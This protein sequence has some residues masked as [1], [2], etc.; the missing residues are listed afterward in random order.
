MSLSVF[1]KCT[2]LTGGS[3][4]RNQNLKNDK[5]REIYLFF[6]PPSRL[7]QLQLINDINCKSAYV[8]ALPACMLVCADESSPRRYSGTFAAHHHCA[9]RAGEL[10]LLSDKRILYVCA[11]WHWFA[12]SQSSDSGQNF[13]IRA[14]RFVANVGQPWC[15]YILASGICTWP[16]VQRQNWKMVEGTLFDISINNKKFYVAFRTTV[17]A[18][19]AARTRRTLARF[20]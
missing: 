13:G 7:I 10:S 4:I 15:A 17:K 14:W 6:L 12:V 11:H 8:Y 2:H 20:H 18:I 3:T 9:I 1:S 5:R 16:G 19:V